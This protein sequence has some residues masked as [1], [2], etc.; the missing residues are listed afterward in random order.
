MAL[1]NHII[2]ALLDRSVSLISQATCCH[3]QK[4]CAIII[5]EDTVNP[6]KNTSTQGENHIQAGPGLITA[7]CLSRNNHSK[8]KDE[9]M[10]GM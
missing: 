5:T 1:K 9:E 10:T 3:F 2:I 8:I 6:S 7:D 4:R